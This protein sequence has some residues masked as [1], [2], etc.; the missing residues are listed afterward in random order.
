MNPRLQ[1]EAPTVEF[2]DLLGRLRELAAARVRICGD[3]LAGEHDY[4]VDRW[5]RDCLRLVRRRRRRVCGGCG[6]G[7][8]RVLIEEPRFDHRHY[9][10]LAPRKRP[11]RKRAA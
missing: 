11:G 10:R 2:D 5:R 7:F 4:D 6:C 3:C 8:G 1:T 9:D